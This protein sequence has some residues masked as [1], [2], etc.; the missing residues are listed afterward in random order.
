MNTLASSAEK[1]ACLLLRAAIVAY[2][3]AISP[4]LGK[5]CR[6]YP[7]CSQYALAAVERHGLLKGLF[8]GAC[9]LMRCNGFFHGGYDPVPGD[10]AVMNA[11]PSGEA[12]QRFSK[13]I[14]AHG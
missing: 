3:A 1:T 6:F 10:D 11:S 14:A 8:L 4:L 12:D 9:R 7:S 2:Q 5:Q 13:G